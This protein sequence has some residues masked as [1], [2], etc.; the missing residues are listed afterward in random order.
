MKER[1]IQLVKQA[2]DE[3]ASE[4]QEDDVFTHFK[5]GLKGT[6][7][8]NLITARKVVIEAMMEITDR[9]KLIDP[10]ADKDIRIW[11][12]CWASFIDMGD[13]W[14]A[15]KVIEDCYNTLLR[16]QQKNNERYPKGTPLQTR[17]EGLF[18]MGQL[19]RAKRFVILA[20]IEDLITGQRTAPAWQTLK[21]AGMSDQDLGL[22]EQETMSL[23]QNY[24]AK[25]QKLLYPEEVFQKVQYRIEFATLGEVNRNIIYTNSEYLRWLLELVEAAS[26]GNDASEKRITLENLAQYL[27]SSIEGFNVEPSTRTGP[28]ELDGIITNSSNHPF[29]RTLD[30]YIPIECKNWREPTGSPEVTQFIGKLSL[31]KCNTGILISKKGI[32]NKTVNE[33]RK[34]AYRRSNIYILVFDSKDIGSIIQSKDLVSILIEK[35]KELKFSIRM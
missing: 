11:R 14:S 27:F 25:G 1:L 5:E 24:I 28:Y 3:R 29:L 22:I 4:K 20:H 7:H 34:D 21:E 23:H 26:R 12:W 16:L 8:K 9:G 15:D 19:V 13:Q 2:Q 10:S 31:F 17:A 33:L 18:K 32:K 6:I 35:F 30:T